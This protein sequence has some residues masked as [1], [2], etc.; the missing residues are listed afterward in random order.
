MAKKYPLDE[1]ELAVREVGPA[2]GI[3]SAGEALALPLPPPLPFQRTGDPLDPPAEFKHWQREEPIRRVV[4]GGVSAWLVTRYADVR[5][6]LVDARLSSDPTRAGYPA[7]RPDQPAPRRGHLSSMD[8]PEHTELRRV[9][10]RSALVTGV[11]RLRPVIERHARELLEELA[12]LPQPVDLVGRFT[13]ALPVRVICEL[14]GVPFEDREVFEQC[15]SVI[16]RR[17]ASG[18]EVA[19]AYA[20]LIGYLGRLVEAKDR[21]PA[22]DL[23]SELVVQYVGNGR[24]TREQV[25]SLGSLLLIAG[26]A[27]TASQIALSVAAL[28]RHP[29]QLPVLHAG[30]E[31]V[32]AAVDELL[33]YL[34]VV[35]FGLRRVA[36]ADISVGRSVIRAGDG[37][38]LALQSAN[39]DPDIFP[40]PDR[41][42][43]T[44]STRAHV[45]FG[46]GPHR[47]PG[48]ALARAQLEIALPALF[49]RLPGLQL[50]IPFEEL[51]FEE[52]S[53]FHGLRELPVV[54]G[55]A[56]GGAREGKG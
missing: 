16:A 49:R 24:I 53:L 3:G 6:L 27:T 38:V 30:P 1:G 52:D 20:S 48:Q 37:V 39:R 45:A 34:T 44:R 11:G 46:Y 13:L 14:F 43:L 54:W 35:H 8:A 40:D 23:L 10:M 36:T 56:H 21:E 41:L 15:A 28:L 17:S 42:D 22:D 2:Q 4:A 33:R 25:V 31:A 9:V 51:P 50:A 5:R 19:A 29:D 7:I 26:H 32:S 12:V 18:A 55:S 47:C